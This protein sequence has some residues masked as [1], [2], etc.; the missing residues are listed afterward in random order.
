M[1]KI[2][3]L[4][5]AIFNIS[6]SF[7]QFCNNPI[8][9]GR[10]AQICSDAKNYVVTNLNDSGSGSLREALENPEPRIINFA[11]SGTIRLLSDLKVQS[12][13]A[14]DGSGQNI[15]ICGYTLVLGQENNGVSNII[16]RNL[17]FYNPKNIFPAGVFDN[18]GN[19]LDQIGIYSSS[20]IWIDHCTFGRSADDL[21]GISHGA[22]D[23]TISWCKFY[24]QAESISYGNS[25]EAITKALTIGDKD[26]RDSDKGK[27]KVTLE[28]NYFVNI[29]QRIPRVRYG[30]IHILN[31]YFNST[32]HGGRPSMYVAYGAQLYVQKNWLENMG[33]PS[34]SDSKSGGYLKAESN[35][36]INT[37]PVTEFSP[38]NVSTTFPYAFQPESADQTLKNMIT[39]YAGAN[40]TGNLVISYSSGTL[41]SPTGR[42]YQWYF[43]GNVINGANGNTYK[44]TQKGT[45][46]V[47]IYGNNNCYK[48]ISYNVSSVDPIGY[49][50][51]ADCRVIKG[52]A[53]DGDKTDESIVLHIYVDGKFHS[54]I[55]TEEFRFDVNLSN[56]LTGK[57]GFLWPVPV[58]LRDGKTHL[59]EVYSLNFPYGQQG[60]N[61]PKI[62]YTTIGGCN[63]DEPVGLIESADCNAISGWVIDPEAKEKS[64]YVHIYID[65]KMEASVLSNIPRPEINNRLNTTG[66]HEFQWN[67]PVKYK[68]GKS[69]QYELYLLNFPYGSPTASNPK[70]L[71][72]NIV[73]CNTST[74]IGNIDSVGCESVSGWVIDLDSSAISI[75]MHV[76]VDGKMTAI[77]KTDITRNDVNSL[78]NISGKHGFNW[79][80]PQ[81]LMDGNEHSAT[82]FAINYPLGTGNNSIA[83]RSFKC[84]MGAGYTTSITPSDAN[85]D[86]VLYPN[87]FNNRIYINNFNGRILEV[88]LFNIMG[89]EVISSLLLNNEPILSIAEENLPSGLYF[90]EIFTTEKKYTGKLIRE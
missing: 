81:Y 2:Y 67:I 13:K 79:V 48:E 50:E 53:F 57:H 90:I 26:G 34:K 6:L 54:S 80:I 82:F 87:P 20:N 55:K 19:A 59:I 63:A 7:A 27:L 77:L 37:P 47:R 31:N 15:T 35:T 28:H 83:V 14:V 51:N 46:T 39:T 42:S 30:Q 43:S 45:Y 4:A 3:L 66:N 1:K 52:W 10:N 41:F 72:T 32:G 70:I 71:N 11:V 69:H 5:L 84:S 36:L 16:L 60:S 75:D 33:L 64:T 74:P 44:P 88:K 22:T 73:S 61:N 40:T 12:C 62:L 25:K 68:D 38:Q 58:S 78:Y 86:L 85:N 23:I 8:G 65:G 24:D 76:Y 29:N 18:E 49:T 56:K 21:I 89:Q 9:F 17:T